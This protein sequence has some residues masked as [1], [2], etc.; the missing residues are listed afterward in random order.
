MNT[1]KTATFFANAAIKNLFLPEWMPNSVPALVNKR[2][3]I[4]D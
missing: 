3:T 4:E 2:L 1:L